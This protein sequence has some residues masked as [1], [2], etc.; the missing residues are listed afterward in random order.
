MRG[1]EICIYECIIQYVWERAD[2]SIRARKCAVLT[3]VSGMKAKIQCLRQCPPL[4][5]Y[6]P[7]LNICHVHPTS[8]LSLFTLL[9]CISCPPPSRAQYR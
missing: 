1:I 3:G 9:A 8:L 4:L 7:S 5:L 2:Y 6:P